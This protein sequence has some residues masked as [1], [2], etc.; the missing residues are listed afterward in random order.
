MWSGGEV[1]SLLVSEVETVHSV[2]KPTT[3]SIDGDRVTLKEM[4]VAQSES[5]LRPLRSSS[6]RSCDATLPKLQ[7]AKPKK[8]R[9]T[10][11]TI[12]K[13]TKNDDILEEPAQATKKKCQ[14]KTMD[15]KSR[16]ALQDSIKSTDPDI[17]VNE[18]IAA[19]T[20]EFSDSHMSAFV[21]DVCANAG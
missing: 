13:K 21:A 15:K 18:G 11:K 4:Q 16:K 8:K 17:L 19:L 9:Q 2:K 1:S 3:T 5:V 10:A 20:E 14:T 6:R 12:A 7:L